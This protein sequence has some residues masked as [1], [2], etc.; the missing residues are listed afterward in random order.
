MWPRV[1][2]TNSAAGQSQV[3]FGHASRGLG[4][5]LSI[6]SRV[7]ASIEQAMTMTIGLPE[8]HNKAREE[9]VLVLNAYHALFSVAASMP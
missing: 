5:D 4:Q 2:P 3:V 7:H 6:T 9:T 8:V 1:N